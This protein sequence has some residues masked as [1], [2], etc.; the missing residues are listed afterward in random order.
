MN[1]QYC[2]VG[3]ATPITSGN[4]AIQ[5]LEVMYQNFLDKAANVSQADTDLGEFFK[6][7]A[8]GLKKVLESLP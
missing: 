1:N 5:V 3:A 8:R 2:K 4:Q 6:R 7:K